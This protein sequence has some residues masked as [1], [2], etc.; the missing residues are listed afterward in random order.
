MSFYSTFFAWYDGEPENRARRIYAE[1][2]SRAAKNFNDEP[3]YGV[4][5]AETIYVRNMDGRDFK[6]TLDQLYGEETVESK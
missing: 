6:Y 2:P 1:C 3:P 5:S 4:K